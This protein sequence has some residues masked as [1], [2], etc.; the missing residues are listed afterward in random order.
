MPLTPSSFFPFLPLRPLNE[1]IKS[2]RELLSSLKNQFNNKKASFLLENKRNSSFEAFLIYIRKKQIEAILKFVE[3]ELE[4]KEDWRMF[5]RRRDSRKNKEE[6]D[7]H[8]TKDGQKEPKQDNGKEEKKKEEEVK[9]QN[10]KSQ[11][12]SDKNKEEKNRDI[13]EEE[14]D[15]DEWLSKVEEE[16]A[17]RVEM[18]DGDEG[19]EED[20]WGEMIRRMKER[21]QQL[22]EFLEEENMAITN[23]NEAIKETEEKSNS[24]T[25][26]T[27]YLSVCNLIL[28]FSV[29]LSTFLTFCIVFLFLFPLPIFFFCCLGS[30]RKST[31]YRK[32][33]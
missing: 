32:E 25:E 13:K 29:L 4:G 16:I 23:L 19:K 17:R 1:F 10:E 31:S 12:E 15:V 28:A 33:Q 2:D 26:I 30:I 22:E 18:D 11:E 3:E 14:D 27:E 7:M 9:N 6:K 20:E 8:R 5:F 24:L 21:H